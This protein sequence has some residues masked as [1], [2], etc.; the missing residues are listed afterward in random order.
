MEGIRYCSRPGEIH[1][2]AP[3]ED[4]SVNKNVNSINRTATYVI[5]MSGGVG[6]VRLLPIP[7]MFQKT[8]A[9]HRNEM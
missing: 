9:H 2:C 1:I 8:K 4:A 6:A 3:G 5:R 7:I